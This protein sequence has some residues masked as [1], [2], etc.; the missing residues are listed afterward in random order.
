MNTKNLILTV[1]TVISAITISFAQESASSGNWLNAFSFS[2]Y[3][4]MSLC[5]LMLTV[6]WLLAR[7]IKSLTERMR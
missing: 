5:G 1:M 7:T 4:L 6:I 3:L 2:E